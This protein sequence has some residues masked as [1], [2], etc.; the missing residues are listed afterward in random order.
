MKV[1]PYPGPADNGINIKSNVRLLNDQLNNLINYVV[2]D[3]Q[4]GS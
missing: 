4:R 1:P 3:R 2:I